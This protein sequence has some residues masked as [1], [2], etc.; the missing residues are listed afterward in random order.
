MEEYFPWMVENA[1]WLWAAA[2]IILLASEMLAPGVYLLWIGLA[3]T[4]TG[5]VAWLFPGLGFDGHGLIFAALG[6]AS[7]Y[8]GHRYFY[9]DK[10]TVEEMPVN[11]R[12]QNHVG[13]VYQV[14]EPIESG[15]GHV[16]VGDGRWLAEGPDSAVGDM[17]RVISVEGTILKV[18]S[19][20]E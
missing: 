8:L 11:R 5:V 4:V 9:S 15:R 12:G 1:P 7:I 17:V 20:S 2:G 14:V 6:T 3:A 18:E 13:K 19:V 10:A 16:S